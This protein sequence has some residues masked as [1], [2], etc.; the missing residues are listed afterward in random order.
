MA[1][2]KNLRAVASSPPHATNLATTSSAVNSLPG[3]R[4]C[5]PLIHQRVTDQLQRLFTWHS[6]NDFSGKFFECAHGH[7]HNIVL[8]VLSRKCDL[9]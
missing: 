5:S 6:G 8:F 3:P 2:L 1:A 4:S 9:L 7:N